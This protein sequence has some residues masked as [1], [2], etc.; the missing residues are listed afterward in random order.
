M[1]SPTFE[2]IPEANQGYD[3]ISKHDRED[4]Q[5]NHRA[6]VLKTPPYGSTCRSRPSR[7]CASAGTRIP[8][9]T[10]HSARRPPL[11]H[12]R[13]KE[14]RGRSRIGWHKEDRTVKHIQVTTKTLPRL[15]SDGEC[16]ACLSETGDDLS[17]CV[18]LGRCPAGWSGTCV[19]Q[20]LE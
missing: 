7:M 2:T 8:P 19:I 16:C 15:A 20:L 3:I 10:R 17:K 12:S 5:P 6:D 11:R 1:A 18:K 4:G 13:L 9:V 14:C